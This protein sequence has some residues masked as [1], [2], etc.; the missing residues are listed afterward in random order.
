[1]EF[2]IEIIIIAVL[3]L[4]FGTTI[5]IAIRIDF[6]PWRKFVHERRVE[7]ARRACTHVEIKPT[8]NP[9]EFLYHSLFESPPMTL[10]WICSRCGTVTHSESAVLRNQAHWAENPELWVEQEKEFA[11]LLRKL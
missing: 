5:A 2:T 4:I 11:K 6:V 10:S 3:A 9:N 1:M 8:G 7:R